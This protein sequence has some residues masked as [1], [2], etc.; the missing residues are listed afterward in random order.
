MKTLRGRVQG[1]IGLAAVLL[2]F[3]PVVWAADPNGAATLAATP[4]APVDYVWVLLCGFLV[5][6]MQAGFAMVETGFC[7]AKNA[8]NLMAKNT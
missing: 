2:G 8:T 4:T 7:R 5:F 6:F 1:G 3:A